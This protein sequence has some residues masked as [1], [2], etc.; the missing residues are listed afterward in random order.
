[1]MPEIGLFSKGDQ[2]CKCDQKLLIKI[3]DRNTFC[4]YQMPHDFNIK[5]NLEDVGT[6]NVN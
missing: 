2:I 1:M 4:N 6:S 3:E 5:R